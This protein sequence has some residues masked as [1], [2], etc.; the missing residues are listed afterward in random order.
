MQGK[1]KIEL[2][3][4]CLCN[5]NWLVV[6]M[7]FS[8]GVAIIMSLHAKYL[9]LWQQI[10]VHVDQDMMDAPLQKSEVRS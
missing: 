5:P 1:L 3:W 7:Q 4:K 6:T 10:L 8:R 2:K 9:L